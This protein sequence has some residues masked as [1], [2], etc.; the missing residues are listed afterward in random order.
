MLVKTT[1][2]VLTSKLNMFAP[3]IVDAVRS[4]AATPD[5]LYNMCGIIDIKWNQ[6]GYVQK[7]F[8][9]K[10]TAFKKIFSCAGFEQTAKGSTSSRSFY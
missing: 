8:L 6:G 2:T 10:G 5:G 9:V 4:L 1:S 3:M 7:S